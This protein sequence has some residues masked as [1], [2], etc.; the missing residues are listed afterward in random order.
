MQVMSKMK[1][2]KACIRGGNLN[3][4]L[5]QEKN[6]D[7]LIPIIKGRVDKAWC[8]NDYESRVEESLIKV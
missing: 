8:L 4:I 3:W 2:N 7:F 1:F 6:P 5:D